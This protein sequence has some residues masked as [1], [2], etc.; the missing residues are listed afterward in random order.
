MQKITR[1]YDNTVVYDYMCICVCLG[2]QYNEQDSLINVIRAY[3]ITTLSNVHPCHNAK[4]DYMY[5]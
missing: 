1:L 3:L 5:I 4:D 2:K